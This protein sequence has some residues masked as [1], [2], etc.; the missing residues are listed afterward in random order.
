M[1]YCRSLNMYA[2]CRPRAG[3]AATIRLW[4]KAGMNVLLIGARGSGKTSILRALAERLD[5]RSVDLDDLVLESFDQCTV[6]DVWATHGEPA[7]R[8]AE[9]RTLHELLADEDDRNDATS[10]RVIALGG[11]VPLIPEARKLLENAVR[12]GRIDIVYL[13]AS[14]DTLRKRLIHDPGDRPS[15]T[16]ADPIDEIANVL[17]HRD[18]VYR[19]LASIIVATDGKSIEAIVEEISRKLDRLPPGS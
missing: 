13:E 3:I 1:G 16:G 19:N 4:Y 12:S 2:I 14:V 15:L 5:Q 8:A 18:P 17:A 9:V 6:E 7:W 10:G 11:G